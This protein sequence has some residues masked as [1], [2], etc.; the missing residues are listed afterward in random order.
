MIIYGN[1]MELWMGEREIYIYIYIHMGWLNMFNGIL[2]G[3]IVNGI[4]LWDLY[5]YI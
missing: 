3:Y 2:M 5:I 1:R 4:I